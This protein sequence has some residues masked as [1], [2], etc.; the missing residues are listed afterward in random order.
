[1]AGLR[2]PSWMWRWARIAVAAAILGYLFTLAP[3]AEVVA[4]ARGV[5]VWP[6]LA[7]CLLAL[8]SQLAVAARLRRLTA[9][10]GLTLPTGEL[11]QINLATLFYGLFLPAGNITGVIARFYRIAWRDKKYAG[12]AV[13]LLFD[14]MVATLALCAVGIAAF[15][16]AF[17]GDGRL[18]LGLMLAAL[19]AL[20]L[21]HLALFG[22]L[23]V[24]SLERARHRLG[25]RLRQRLAS[26]HEALRAARRLPRRVLVQ[27]AALAV[28]VHLIGTL[29]YAVLAGALGL[30]LSLAT[31]AWVR[32]AAVL[33]AILPVS[34][35][36]LGVREGA[37]VVL[38]APYGV[39]TA[40]ALAFSL[41]AFAATI[42]A[43]GLI[44]GLLEAVRVL[45]PGLPAPK[46][47]APPGLLAAP[48]RSKDLR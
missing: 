1:M 40:E 46:A 9:A 16:W 12:T 2:L 18:A 45:A 34:V 31:I 19:A 21:A 5:G 30:E 24:A 39:G 27:V 32:A 48:Q 13:A 38:L 42:L 8:G 4:A 33:I 11:F 25:G 3:V 15:L 26:L 44:G 20:W 41:L 29:A 10:Q 47:A 14:R 28:L 7:A 35:S 17:P 23:R 22:E 36:G 6:L 37:I 43:L